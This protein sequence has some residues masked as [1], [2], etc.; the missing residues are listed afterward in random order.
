MQHHPFAWLARPFATMRPTQRC[1]LHQPR[2]MQLRLGPG[3]APPKPMLLANV[4]ME[5]LHVPSHVVRAVFT[6]HPNH[7]IDRHA[8]GRFLAKPSVNQP[9]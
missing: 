8:S 4:I 5:M 1:A 7:L 9:R 2:R 6:E 3:V